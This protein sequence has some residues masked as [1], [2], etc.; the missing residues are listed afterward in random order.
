MISVS[1]NCQTRT[2]T[3]VPVERLKNEEI[4]RIGAHTDFCTLTLLFQDNVGGLEVE[5][6]NHAGTFRVCPSCLLCNSFLLTSRQS[7]APVDGAV[8]VNAGDFLQRCELVS[9]V[10]RMQGG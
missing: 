7:A 10:A 5:D 4:T 1:R 2:C 8:A 6:P 9:T 3:S